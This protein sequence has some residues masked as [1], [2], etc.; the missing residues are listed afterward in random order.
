METLSTCRTSRFDT[1]RAAQLVKKF[2]ASFRIRMCVPLIDTVRHWPLFWN[3]KILCTPCFFK[4][5]SNVILSS[6][7]GLFHD[8]F[9]SVYLNKNFVCVSYHILGFTCPHLA[10]LDFIALIISVEQYALWTI[11]SFN[12]LYA[13]IAFCLSNVLIYR[14]GTKS[15]F[16]YHCDGPRF[17]NAENKRDFAFLF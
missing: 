3:R 16:I 5:H 4:I 15:I 7:P 10:L 13:A 14:S 1:V 12:C 9:L 6:T 17:K 11:S 2:L 8:H